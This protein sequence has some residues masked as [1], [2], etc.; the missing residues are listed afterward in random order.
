M[1]EWRKARKKAVEV[2][3]RE[4]HGLTEEI[5]TREGILVAHSDKDFIIR[6]VEGESYPITKRVFYKTYSEEL[7]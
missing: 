7:E 4:V 1:G 5:E 2:E 6:G 3:F